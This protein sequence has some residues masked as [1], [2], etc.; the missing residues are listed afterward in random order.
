MR[1]KRKKGNK[2]KPQG[3]RGKP[4]EAEGSGREPIR[5]YDKRESVDRGIRKSFPFARENDPKMRFRA[6]IGNR[7][8]AG[9]VHSSRRSEFCPLSPCATDER[10][11]ERLVSYRHIASNRIRHEEGIFPRPVVVDV[12]SK[13]DGWNR[14]LID[15]GSEENA[16]TKEPP[17]DRSN[18]D[19]LYRRRDP[20]RFRP[21][22]P[23]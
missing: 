8:E 9:K 6:T 7:D 17:R 3:S 22:P 12:F 5:G 13:R 15:F 16:K 10:R 18:R 1:D 20:F 4:R 2:G 11:H 23:R 21:I 19:E 14:V